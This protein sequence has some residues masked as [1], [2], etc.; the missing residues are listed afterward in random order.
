MDNLPLIKCLTTFD[1]AIAPVLNPCVKQMRSP[2]SKTR[3]N[4]QPPACSAI[5]KDLPLVE[6]IRQKM[7]LVTSVEKHKR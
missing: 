1:V 4:W 6:G 2:F 7:L 3:E 5:N